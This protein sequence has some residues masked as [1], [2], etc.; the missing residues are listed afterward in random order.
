MT[1][2]QEAAWV[3]EHLPRKATIMIRLHQGDIT[4]HPSGL[5]FSA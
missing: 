5:A 4:T 1:N 2:R 3:I